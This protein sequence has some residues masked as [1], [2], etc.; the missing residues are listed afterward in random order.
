VR[1]AFWGEEFVDTPVY[2]GTRL[3]EGAT[4]EGPALIEEPYTVVVLPPDA[5]AS[6]DGLGNYVISV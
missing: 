1:A 5:T 3:G 4:I 2:D 6:L